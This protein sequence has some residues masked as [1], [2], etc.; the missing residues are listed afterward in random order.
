MLVVEKAV[1]SL[2]VNK[3]QA[4]ALAEIIC[5]SPNVDHAI[6]LLFGEYKEPL[7]HSKK[8]GR[9]T[10]EKY[11]FI[12]YC[13]WQD[14][15]HYKYSR[16][17]SKNIYISKD[18]DEMLVTYENYKDYEEGWVEGKNRK[19]ITVIFPETETGTSSLSKSEWDKLQSDYTMEEVYLNDVL[20]NA[21][22]YGLI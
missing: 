22:E 1:E 5:Q 3:T 6:S 21:E 17:K 13:P 20:N 2:L 19:L 8:F 11:E 18:T 4:K 12:S 16:P 7:F 10:N 15:V 9:N 14:R